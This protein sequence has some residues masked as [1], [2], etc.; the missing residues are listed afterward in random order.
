MK[1]PS[2]VVITEAAVQVVGF[3]IVRWINTVLGRGRIVS[4]RI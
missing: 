1:E 3:I 2:F 4:T